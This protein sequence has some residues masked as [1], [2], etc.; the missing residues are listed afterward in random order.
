MPPN[1]SVRTGTLSGTVMSILPNVTSADVFRTIV[2]AVIGA[3]TS[4]VFTILLR[5]IHQSK[6][7][8]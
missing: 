1:V 3:A 7:K 6:T 8:R 4:Y 5:K 2:L